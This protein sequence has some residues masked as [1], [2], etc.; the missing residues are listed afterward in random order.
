MA[1]RSVASS[2]AVGL[3]FLLQVVYIIYFTVTRYKCAHT[4]D[5]TPMG[6]H[7]MINDEQSVDKHTLRIF[8]EDW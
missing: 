5:R 6:D 3:L 7:V 2:K 1:P 8:N 4:Q